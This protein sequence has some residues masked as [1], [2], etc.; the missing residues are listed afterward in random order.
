MNYTRDEL[1]RLGC[2]VKVYI[3]KILGIELYGGVNIY[4]DE[5]DRNKY[6][7]RFKV[8]NVYT[9]K[10]ERIIK[11]L[12]EGLGVK[13]FELHEEVVVIRDY[14]YY[15]SCELV[16]ADLCKWDSMFRIMGF[17]RY[18]HNIH[19]RKLAEKQEAEELDS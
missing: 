16:R 13:G 10:P 5:E 17:D 18:G 6:Y 11:V 15:Y 8:M 7:I 9:D 12:E 14:T 1:Y 19:Y 2:R 4:R 3:E